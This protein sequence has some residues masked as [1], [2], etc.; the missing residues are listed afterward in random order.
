MVTENRVA[1]R[2]SEECA[3]SATSLGLALSGRFWDCAFRKK[4]IVSVILSLYKR[5]FT[6]H[7]QHKSKK[8]L[9]PHLQSFILNVS[10]IV[11]L[12]Q[13]M[14]FF[15]LIV[16]LTPFPR[17]LILATPLGPCLYD[18]HISSNIYIYICTC[19]KLNLHIGHC[20]K[21]TLRGLSVF[22]RRF[23]KSHVL[24]FALII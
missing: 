20:Q 14:N 7:D 13:T 6:K 4:V 12:G 19:K 3:E 2:L 15:C 1:Q 16:Y 24:V 9:K 10:C 17:C 21:R 5:L 8:G 18:L 22:L 11:N 23:S